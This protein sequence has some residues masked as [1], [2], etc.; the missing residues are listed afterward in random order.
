MVRKLQDASD[1]GND[2]LSVRESGLTYLIASKSYAKSKECSAREQAGLGYYCH[3]QIKM[4]CS[5]SVCVA[6]A[7]DSHS[8]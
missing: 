8:N 1:A 7:Y 6:V 5:V 4:E 3:P 2:K